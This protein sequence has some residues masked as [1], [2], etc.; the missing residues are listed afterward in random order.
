MYT[1]Q[2]R[3]INFLINYLITK[4]K[5]LINCLTKAGQSQ[6]LTLSCSSHTLHSLEPAFSTLI[7]WF[8]LNNSESVTAVALAFSSIQ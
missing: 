8:S 5:T 7:C 6:Y 2:N 1:N 3:Q 4:K